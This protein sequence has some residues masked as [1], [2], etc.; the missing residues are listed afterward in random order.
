MKFIN[1][2]KD[3]PIGVGFLILEFSEFSQEDEWD[4]RT[5]VRYHADYEEWTKEIRNLEGRNAEYVALKVQRP[6][7]SLKVSIVLNG[8]V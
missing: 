1:S 3:I 6:E 4:V 2:S 7:V 5:T 8:T